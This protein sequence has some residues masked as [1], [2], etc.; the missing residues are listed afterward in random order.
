MTNISILSLNVRGLGNNQKRREIS[1]WLRE[2]N[3]SSYMLQ[4]VHCTEKTLETWAAEW[5]YTALFSGLATNK[6]VVAILQQQ[7]HFQ[8]FETTMS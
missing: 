8:S 6:A 7:L 5:G 3:Y 2:K 4:K 1:Q